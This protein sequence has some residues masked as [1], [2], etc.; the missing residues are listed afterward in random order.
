MSAFYLIFIGGADSRSDYD[1]ETYL[2]SPSVDGVAPTAEN[3]TSGDYVLQRDLILCTKGEPTG[4]TK[5][6]ISWILSSEGQEIVSEEFVPL[7]ASDD[8]LEPVG[9]VE[10]YVGG[11]TTIQ[12]IMIK[13]VDRYTEKYGSDRVSISIMAG[14]SGVGASNTAQGSFDIGM[15][16]RDLTESEKGLGLKETVIGKD[17]VALLINC[18]SI[19]DISLVDVAGIFSG[20]VTNWSQLGGVDLSI[21]PLVRDETSG[22]REC[23]DKIMAEAVSGWTIKPGIP[24]FSSTNGVVNMVKNT[25]GAIGYVSIGV[26]KEILNE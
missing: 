21:K 12:P 2:S 19:T 22:T 3:I 23:F 15:C 16:S 25:P 18:A 7:E 1:G 5:A 6:F 4:N 26:L 9:T 8:Y 10:L 11:S 20:D 13:L 24:E 14:G 17:G